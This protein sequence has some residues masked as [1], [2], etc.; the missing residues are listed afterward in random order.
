[1]TMRVLMKLPSAMHAAIGVASR[2]AS[3]GERPKPPCSRSGAKK[4]SENITKPA[5]ND[6]VNSVL[7]CASR[8]MS[9]GL[10]GW[11]ARRPPSADRGRHAAHRHAGAERDIG[12]RETVL[13]QRLDQRLEAA[14]HQRDE[15]RA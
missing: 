4:I 8:K 5:R 2:P 7:S 14:E 9:S 3:C 15:R 13:R 11:G 10:I 6:S 12:R 1:M